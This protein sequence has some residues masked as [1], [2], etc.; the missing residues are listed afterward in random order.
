MTAV[1]SRWR[2][3]WRRVFVRRGSAVEGPPAEATPQAAVSLSSDVRPDDPIME[4]FRTAQGVL[5][6]DEIPVDSPALAALRD[7]GVQ[8][9]V[10]LVS[11]DDVLGLLTLGPRA[12]RLDYSAEDRTLLAEIAAQVTPA[13]RVAQLVRLRQ[14]EAEER[15]RIDRELQIARSIQLTLLP[16]D[17]PS[18]AGYEIAALYRPA[19][20]VGGDFYDFLSLEDGRVG[21]VMGDVT[22]KG[23]PAALVMATTRS[24]MRGV[25][26]RLAA[27]GKVLAQVNDLLCPDVPT[28]MFV[29]CLFAVLDPATGLLRY[30]NAG[31]DPPYCLRDGAVL[32]LR[33]R[34][35]P[36]G[37]MPGME[38]DEK[39]AR[40]EPGDTV[41]FYSDGIVEAHDPDRQIYGFPRLAS[42]VSAFD[43]TTRI[44]LIDHVLRSLEQFTGADWDQE[45]DITAVT[46]NCVGDASDAMKPSIHSGGDGEAAAP[47]TEPLAAFTIASVDGNE[48]EAI[49]RVTEAVEPLELPRATIDRLSTAVGEITMNA[50]EHGNAHRADLP[51][52]IQ[53]LYRGDRLV[54]RITDAGTGPARPSYEVPDLDAKLAELQSPRGWGLFLIE[55]MVDGMREYHDARGHTVEIELGIG[56][57]GKRMGGEPADD[58]A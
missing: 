46:L 45:D 52:E 58:Q 6:L 29:T 16:R 5:S 11:Q 50:I 3:F 48:R 41:I 40:I 34:G 35:M 51:V 49:R 33:A 23:V 31:H 2:P 54:V 13:V 26:A 44:T 39:Q 1:M 37:I 20:E 7:A 42:T 38:Y 43:P 27:P 9:V 24:I 14:A 47:E 18:V 10:P 4:Y 25:A 12:N 15:E 8:L 36:L 30:A 19:R 21:I 55:K 57:A 53:V 28:N 17:L 22:D 32:E 56:D